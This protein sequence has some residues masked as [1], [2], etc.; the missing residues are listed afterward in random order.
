MSLSFE[1]D[2]I[3]FVGPLGIPRAESE[4][5][6]L[7]HY[8]RLDHS[9]LMMT[10]SFHSTAPAPPPQPTAPAPVHQINKNVFHLS[11]FRQTPTVISGGHSSLVPAPPPSSR[12]AVPSKPPPDSLKAE[13]RSISVSASQTPTITGSPQANSNSL[14]HSHS[15]TS[16]TKR[17]YRR[18]PKPDPNAP[19]KPVSA[20]VTFSSNLRNEES[21]KDK[22]F[23][24][25]SVLVGERWQALPKAVK[26]AS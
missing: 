11:A 9:W 16:G 15:N 21:L 12:P 4:S 23:A 1:F 26:E 6:S 3:G 10:P 22:T 24:E 13:S 25:M 7:S 2:F 5:E 17:R 19:V 14:P 20:F 8:A 18:H